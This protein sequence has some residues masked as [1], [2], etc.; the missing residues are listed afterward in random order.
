MAKGVG[1][2]AG[3]SRSRPAHF[4]R[5][6]TPLARHR[7]TAPRGPRANTI[8][9]R[10]PR[11]VSAITAPITTPASPLP[12]TNSLARWANQC[13]SIA[14]PVLLTPDP[15]TSGLA[16]IGIMAGLF[17]LI[18]L[19]ILIITRRKSRARDAAP[20]NG[21]AHDLHSPPG[22]SA[23]PPNP[24]RPERKGPP[25]TQVKLQPGGLP[26]GV[27]SIPAG[28][29]SKKPS[30]GR[31]RPGAKPSGAHG[32]PIP[33]QKETPAER[34]ARQLREAQ[35]SRQHG[36]P[37]HIIAKL[38]PIAKAGAVE[39]G[40]FDCTACA[41]FPDGG[42]GIFTVVPTPEGKREIRI[43]TGGE[44]VTLA[45]QG[46]SPEF[47]GTLTIQD[48]GARGLLT[49]RRAGAAGNWKIMHFRKTAGPTGGL[50]STSEP[51]KERLGE[52][53]AP[54]HSLA[55]ESPEDRAHRLGERAGGT[56]TAL[57]SIEDLHA[58]FAARRRGAGGN[59]AKYVIV[60]RP[61]GRIEARLTRTVSSHDAADDDE[62]MVA[63][64]LIYDEQQQ[65]RVLINGHSSGY[66]TTEQGIDI[67]HTSIR[68]VPLHPIAERAGLIAAHEFLQTLFG[69]SVSVVIARNQ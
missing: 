41:T 22:G 35:L 65:Q 14:G 69:D 44:P 56:L 30:D 21:G 40:W 7:T 42:S 36:H 34:E 37:V 61:D 24:R 58:Q 64:G 1:M 46:E 15:F 33:E 48:L 32:R 50:R 20:P 6:Q 18:A 43:S 28:P 2:R 29:N 25:R 3:V 10:S 47:S 59:A 62:S 63:A 12:R 5:T 49:L 57:Q 38:D 53:S 9:D 52:I 55:N 8:A 4:M 66:P 54:D 39:T 26:S 68:G 11:S 17:T 19:P 23:V 31:E 67:A 51:R 16:I 60:Q 27:H 13:S 45:L